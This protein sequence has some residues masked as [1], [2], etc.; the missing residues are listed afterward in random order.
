MNLKLEQKPHE[1]PHSSFINWTEICHLVVLPGQ[2]SN[3]DSMIMV[4]GGFMPQMNCY[5]H[6]H[7]SSE[8]PAQYDTSPDCGLVLIYFVIPKFLGFEEMLS[9]GCE[10]PS[11]LCNP[12]SINPDFLGGFLKLNWVPSS[13]ATT[14]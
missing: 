9:I 2:R 7:V 13:L 12:D 10:I 11:H 8:D 3:S 14:T 4:S 5:E 1:L 6:I